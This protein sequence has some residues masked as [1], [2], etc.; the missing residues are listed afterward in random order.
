MRRTV[1]R[2]VGVVKVLTDKARKCR[3][4]IWVTYICKSIYP[5]IRVSHLVGGQ[6]GA[7]HPPISSRTI[8]CTKLCSTAPGHRLLWLGLIN[9][10]RMLQ[11]CQ[12][13]IVIDVLV[14]VPEH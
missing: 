11:C 3:I 9:H 13:G 2:A 7:V 12:D 10:Q 6:V 1:S 5:S 8:T 14:L 4:L